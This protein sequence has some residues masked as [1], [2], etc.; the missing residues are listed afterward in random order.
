MPTYEY[1]CP[2]CGTRFERFQK[3]TA[4]P[5]APCPKCGTKAERLISGGTGVL[6]KG[7][8]FY[9]TDY[10]RPSEKAKHKAKEDREKST[11]SKPDL[12]KP[13]AD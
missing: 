12:P 8:G 4:K 11:P 6:F 7:S 3:I 9:E 5:G 2:S 1:K 13:K 10:K